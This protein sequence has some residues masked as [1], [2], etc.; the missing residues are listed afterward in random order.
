M[1]EE[2]QTAFRNKQAF[3]SMGI[4][5]SIKNVNPRIQN[6]DT[7]ID[8]LKEALTKTINRVSKLQ[9]SNNAVHLS[10]T[11]SNGVDKTEKI[12]RKILAATTNVQTEYQ[13]SPEMLKIEELTKLVYQ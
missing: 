9:Q 4:A 13:K 10:N 1:L 12:T 5:N 7:D 11:P 3:G 2:D 8:F 6:L